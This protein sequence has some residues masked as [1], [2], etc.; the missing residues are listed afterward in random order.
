MKIVICINTAWNILNFRKGL[1]AALLKDGHEVVALAPRD[2]CAERL[3][4]LGCKFVDM[5]MPNGGTNPIE[6]LRLLFRLRRFFRD[7]D[8]DVLLS[9]TAKP[10]IYGALA[11]RAFGVP[12]INNVAGLGAVFIS[13]SLVTL[14]VK[15]LYRAALRSTFCTFFQNPSD[16]DLFL[17]AGLVDAARA[18]LVPGSGINLSEFQPREPESQTRPFRFLLI[19]RMLRD[20]GVVEFV[21]AARQLAPKYP[22]VEFA[23]LG[24]TDYNNPAAISGRQVEEWVAKGQVIYLGTREDVRAEIAGA[25]CVVLPSYREGTPR[26]LLEAAAM[27]K[28]IVTTDTAGC[29]EVVT[30]GVNG[31]LCRVADAQDLADK[32]ERMLTLDPVTRSAM[33]VA[34][35]LKMQ[36]EFDE[37]L[38]IAKYKEAIAGAIA[39]QSRR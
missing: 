13:K 12:V 3:V 31:F 33:G 24:A 36:Q 20:K 18:R 27:A 6:D 34:G 15:T 4:A 21:E 19:G 29:R 25:D 32:L 7:E 30:D 10:N 11:A 22:G 8:A 28:P 39:A 17:Q 26:T 1:I 14:V 2:N 37:Q 35:R 16:R 9:Y 5:P 23:L 38:V